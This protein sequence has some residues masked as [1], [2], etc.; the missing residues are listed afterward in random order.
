[1]TLPVTPPGPT[2]GFVRLVIT[3][4]Y[5]GLN[6]HAHTPPC[7]SVTAFVSPTA[8]VPFDYTP[9][10]VT[11]RFAPCYA[12]L[13]FYRRPHLRFDFDLLVDVLPPPW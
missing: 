11:A 12:Y 4:Y 3:L 13:T 10:F 7:A 1:M 6:L 5:V 8:L 9:L 2:R